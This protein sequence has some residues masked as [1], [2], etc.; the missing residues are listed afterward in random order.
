MRLLIGSAEAKQVRIDG[1]EEAPL[2]ED[3]MINSIITDENKMVGFFEDVQSRHGIGRNNTALTIHTNSIQTKVMD[4][5]RVPEAKA[6]E[7]IRREF[8]QY[9]GLGAGE[10]AEEDIY[11]YTILNNK[12]ASGGV[13]LL[14]ASVPAQLL[15]SYRNVL[16]DAGFKLK[17]INVGVNCNVKLV[18]FLPQL[19]QES[20]VLVQADGRNLSLS[21]FIAGVFR[22][23]NRYRLVAELGTKDRLMEIGSNVSSMLQFAVSQRDED[24]PPVGS[25]VFAGFHEAEFSLIA[26]EFAY[27][28]VELKKIDLSDAVRL[29]GPAAEHAES[30]G[31]NP[32][33]YLFNIG[34]MLKK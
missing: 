1:F 16:A 29:S 30:A 3:G 23:T 18:R 34:A 6:L 21:L 32:G 20:F 19:A 28:N 5:P 14:A 2:P 22:V 7:F 33:F 27:L 24:T 10:P 4:V 9:D 12:S 31:F 15:R 8:V 25:A 17:S 26:Q 11:D 13:T